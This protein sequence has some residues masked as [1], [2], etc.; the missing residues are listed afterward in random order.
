VYPREDILCVSVN[1][2]EIAHGNIWLLG[3]H[4]QITMSLYRQIDGRGVVLDPVF[5]QYEAEVT[6]VAAQL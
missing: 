4:M 5:T 2:D 3:A 6:L 1:L